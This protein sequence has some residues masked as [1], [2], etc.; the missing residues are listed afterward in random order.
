MVLASAAAVNDIV[1]IK[2][3]TTINVSSLN[4]DN[5]SS[6][7]L[8]SA[9]LPTVPTTKGGTGLTSIGSAGQALIVNSGAD[10]LEFG[11]AGASTGKVIALSIIFG[12]G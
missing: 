3:Y 11:S 9:R 8:N 1:A 5:I 4:A 6:G 12:A 10:G 7:T 2:A